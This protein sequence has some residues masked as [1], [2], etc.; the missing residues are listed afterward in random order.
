M[1]IPL[2][3]AATFTLLLSAGS[4][5]FAQNVRPA[6]QGANAN[7]QG[8]LNFSGMAQQIFLQSD[9]NHNSILSRREFSTA[10]LLAYNTIANLGRAGLIGRG[11]PLNL[12]MGLAPVGQ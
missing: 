8:A 1:Q 5:A 2:C 6:N 9:R 3:V 11:R 4:P 12:G 7:R 10:Q